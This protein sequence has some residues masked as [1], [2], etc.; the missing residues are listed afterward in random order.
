MP[1]LMLLI[2]LSLLVLPVF[3][4]L[5][6][7]SKEEPLSLSEEASIEELGI[8]LAQLPSGRLLLLSLDS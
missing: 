6:I 8:T 7:E 2:S 4:T 5:N 3:G 1:S